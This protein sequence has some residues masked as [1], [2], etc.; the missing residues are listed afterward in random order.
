MQPLVSQAKC[1]CEKVN[2]E[3]IVNCA[4]ITDQITLS[5]EEHHTDTTNQAALS[6]LVL[7]TRCCA[8]T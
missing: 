4:P 8:A 3:A 6:G 2:S 7:R 1:S 5:R